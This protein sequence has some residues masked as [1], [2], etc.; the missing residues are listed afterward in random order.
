MHHRLVSHV[1]I[2]CRVATVDVCVLLVA[3]LLDLSLP[4]RVGKMYQLACTRVPGSLVDV[5][6][7]VSDFFF[8]GTPPTCSEQIPSGSE[9]I[10]AESKIRR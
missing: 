7:Q 5:L 6:A 9:R 1:A 8:A 2:R 4:P 10:R 3:P